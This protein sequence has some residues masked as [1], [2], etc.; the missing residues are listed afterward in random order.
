MTKNKQNITSTQIANRIPLFVHKIPFHC[1][2][3]DFI[4]FFFRTKN[5]TQKR[6]VF[7]SAVWRQLSNGFELMVWLMV[8]ENDEMKRLVRL[9]NR[10]WVR[11]TSPAFSWDYK[12]WIR[13]RLV[14]SNVLLVAIS[15]RFWSKLK[16]F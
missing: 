11:K 5:E 4:I 14:H 1:I 16:I 2:S 8:W 7:W 3:R 12:Q 10:V 15:S 6:F 9:Q 13:E